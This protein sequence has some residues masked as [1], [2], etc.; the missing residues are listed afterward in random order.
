MIDLVRSRFA[1]FWSPDIWLAPETHDMQQLAKVIVRI[2]RHRNKL[3]SRLERKRKLDVLKY[4]ILGCC[5][6]SNIIGAS[7]VF[8]FLTASSYAGEECDLKAN[9][10]C[11]FAAYRSLHPASS[12]DTSATE[13]PPYLAADEVGLE[14][15][16]PTAPWPSSNDQLTEVELQ[17]LRRLQSIS[18]PREEAK[19]CLDHDRTYA[20][21]IG[22]AEIDLQRLAPC[23]PILQ[24]LDARVKATV[25]EVIK[26]AKIR[27][28]RMRPYKVDLSLIPLKGVKADD[29]PSYPS[30]H[31][32]YGTAVGL[33]F[34]S[35]LPE[36][37]SA[38]Y[39][40]I[41]DY[42]YSR[43][44]ARVHYRSESMRAISPGPRWA[45]PC[46]RTQSS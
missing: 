31:S 14:R 44:L 4:D 46:L 1:P 10:C 7:L 19:A 16:L 18:D 42:G 23:G 8:L 36:K 33:I 30:G 25:E 17:E 45:V 13:Y 43:L 24:V 2:R 20:R 38:I 11:Q 12:S 21:F 39:R 27:F 22:A 26:Q 40:R 15:L 41:E 6:F 35:M 5:A 28:N 9:P 3:S 34:A 32:A 29:A 37:Q